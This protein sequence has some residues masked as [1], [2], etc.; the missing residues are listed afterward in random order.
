MNRM[1]E[2][3]INIH[4][5]L[6]PETFDFELIGIDSEFFNQDVNKLHRP[7][8]DFACLGCTN[9][10]RDVY[11]IFGT[12]QIQEFYNKIEASVHVYCNALYDIRQLRKY[13][14]LP[15][16][17]KIWDIQL[18]E[19]IR[20]S[21][22][23]DSFALNDLARRYLGIYLDKEE[24]KTFSINIENAQ[25]TESQ[26]FYAAV[27]VV[28]TWMIAK[29][30]REQIDE[31]DLNIWK[32]I[33]RPFLWCLLDTGGIK[34]DVKKW[35]ARYTK[36][37]QLAQEL[38]EK[39]PFNPR[40]PKQVKEF[41]LEKYKLKLEGTAE[42]VLTEV[43]KDYPNIPEL[44]MILDARGLAKAAGT[45][46]KSWVDNLEDGMIYPSWKQM[47]AATGRVSAA[48]NYAI[49]TVP[50]DESYRDCL[51][52]EEGTTMVINDYS[53]QEPKLLGAVTGDITLVD[54]FKSKKDVYIAV[55][56]EVFEEKFGK[57]DER[58]NSMKSTILGVSYG[59]SKYGLARKLGIDVDAAEAL[60][61]KF[62]RKFPGVAKWVD[63]CQKWK[64]Y[65]TTLL[66]RKFWLN[67]YANGWERNAQNHPMQGSAADCTKIAVAKLRKNLGYNPCRIYM[68]DELVA[69]FKDG[70]VEMGAKALT[71]AMVSTQEWM[72]PEIPGGCES[73]QGK[74]WSAKK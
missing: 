16:R 34:L 50:H 42:A 32:H 63:E 23:Y 66:G 61:E 22:Y 44:Q 43:A 7:H 51:I 67:P 70:D 59:M 13:A 55:G 28:C 60:L 71:D 21:G 37:L 24:R 53:S 65:T 41:F 35:T 58:R 38:D 8:G 26:I 18:I 1:N 20:F 48:G 45:Y 4:F 36:D 56:F 72:H 17:K 52:A 49:Q 2:N 69:V 46:G 10:G 19:Q 6:P 14:D 39:L 11:M 40:S 47:G 15:D 54:I 27:D 57:K 5:S 73:Y 33:E 64:P 30:Q 9:N 25:M 74:N 29:E 31:D 68:H 62:F 12:D 3:L